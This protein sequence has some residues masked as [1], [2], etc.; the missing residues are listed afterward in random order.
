[1]KNA[2]QGP[3]MAGKQGMSGP[4]WPIKTPETVGGPLNECKPVDVS[5]RL[6]QNDCYKT[7]QAAC[8]ECWC[9]FL[10]WPNSITWPSGPDAPNL[11][12]FLHHLSYFCDITICFILL[13]FIGFGSQSTV[14]RLSAALKKKEPIGEIHIVWFKT[15]YLTLSFTFIGL[16]IHF[17]SYLFGL[18]SYWI[19]L[20]K[21]LVCITRPVFTFFIYYS[22]KCK[23]LTLGLSNTFH[24]ANKR[25]S[26]KTLYKYHYFFLL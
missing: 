17:I 24:K 9:L 6:S 16:F 4:F 22:I 2:E 12:G 26:H 19:T 3:V 7:G 25:I 1:M 15:L 8:W 13:Y 5:S 23:Y 18:N 14:P 20:S 21:V 10:S 11:P